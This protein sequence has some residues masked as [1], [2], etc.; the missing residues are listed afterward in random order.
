MSETGN[1][2]EKKVVE[3]I[4][5]LRHLDKNNIGPD[6]LLVEDL[7]MDS[8]MA[9]EMLFEFEDQYNLEIPDEEMANFKKVKDVVGYLNGI[10][11]K[12]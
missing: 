12:N 4:A 3:T 1:Q 6:S 2:I 8:F 5:R 10:I 9:V 11:P 7:G